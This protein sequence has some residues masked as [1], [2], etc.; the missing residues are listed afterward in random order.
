MAGPGRDPFRAGDELQENWGGGRTEGGGEDGE[1]EVEPENRAEDRRCCL[2]AG[3]LRWGGGEEFGEE[4]PAAFFDGLEQRAGYQTAV[5][6]GECVNALI[7]KA[8][9][10]GD[11]EGITLCEEVFDC[12]LDEDASTERK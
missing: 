6:G 8:G 12:A 5:V 3:L 4:I 11:Q 7:S 1:Q 2:D 9:E 10:G